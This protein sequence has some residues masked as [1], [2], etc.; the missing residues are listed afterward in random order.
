MTLGSGCGSKTLVRMGAGSLKS[1]VVFIFLG[2]S[3][4]M[5]LKRLFALWRI[6]WIDPVAT[7]L[8][9]S[10]VSRQDLPTLISAWTGANLGSVELVV[11]LAVAGALLAFVF[12]DR[13]FR[14][15]FDHLL[16]G[17]VL[18]LLLLAPSYATRHFRFPAN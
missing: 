11:A 18:A 16:G 12:K 5:T 17:T 6:N 7:D 4:Y 1:L 8:T 15:S 13:E 9:R 2:I 14:S 10:N 3:V